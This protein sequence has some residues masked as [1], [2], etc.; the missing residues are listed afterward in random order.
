MLAKAENRVPETNAESSQG[1]VYYTLAGG[2]LRAGR[3]FG[4]SGG[5]L[6][7]WIRFLMCSWSRGWCGSVTRPAK[8][9]FPAERFVR[10]AFPRWCDPA[11]GRVLLDS[12]RRALTGL[13]RVGIRWPGAMAA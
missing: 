9:T 6:L 7:Y 2:W 12:E 10:L 4:L 1:P 3:W 8:Q 5:T 13:F 11:A